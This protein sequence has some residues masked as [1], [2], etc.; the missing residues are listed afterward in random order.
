MGDTVPGPVLVLG[1]RGAALLGAEPDVPALL[2]HAALHPAADLDGAQLYDATYRRLAPVRDGAGTVVALRP[3]T[4]ADEPGDETARRQRVHAQLTRAL[5]SLRRALAVQLLHQQATAARTTASA[6]GGG[7]R[8]PLV[9]TAVTAAGELVEASAVL[10]TAAGMHAV[11]PATVAD[12]SALLADV[13]APDLDAGLDGAVTQ[14]VRDFA[15]GGPRGAAG[16]PP[17][18]PN[19]GSRGHNLL[20]SLFGDFHREQAR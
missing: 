6:V 17:V 10:L 13:A 14:L 3:V 4:G 11:A 8:D 2:G 18:D 12:L 7:V 5:A 19:S 1:G 20:H 16:P 15:S 9:L